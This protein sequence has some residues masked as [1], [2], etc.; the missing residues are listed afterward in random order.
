MAHCTGFLGS[1]EIGPTEQVFL[2]HRYSDLENGYH[3]KSCN[4][5]WDSGLRNLGAYAGSA[6]LNPRLTETGQDRT[7]CQN[8]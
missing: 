2:P 7:K 1:F 3:L 6:P 4:Y 5:T 8:V